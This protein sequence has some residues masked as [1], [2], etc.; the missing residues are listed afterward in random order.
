MNRH[1]R[2]FRVLM[3][4]IAGIA[5]GL[6]AYAQSANGP[7]PTST[8]ATGSGVE[9]SV[10]KI[11]S[12]VRYPDPYK[13]WSK[14]SPV[15][16]VGTGV[17]IKGKRIL[18]N[19]HVVSYASDVQIQANQAGDKLS[20]TVEYIAPGIDLA[21]LKLDDESF[22]DTHPPLDA[23]K[24]LPQIKDPVMAYGYPEGGTSLSITRGIVSRIEFSGYNNGV[25]GLR[26]Q[27]DAAINPGNSGGPAVVG[28]KMVGLVF[29]RLIAAENI[30]YIIPNEEINLFLAD[31]ADGHY[32]GKPAI[33]DEFQTM[34]NPSLRAFLKLDKSVTGMIVHQP[35]NDAADYPLK[36]WDVITHIGET[37]V[38]DQGMIRLGDDVRVRFTYL[39]QKIAKDGKVPLTI[40]RNGQEMKIQ[41]PVM[42][43]LPELVP[44][45][46]NQ[47][48][49]YFIC[50]PMVFTAASKDFLRYLM[51]GDRNG[52]R[53]LVL[54]YTG[55]PLLKR[56]A[57]KPAFD[58]E[59][60]VVV[61]S[62]FFPHRLSMGFSDPYC[63]V[64][65]SINGVP[66]KNLNNLVAIIRDLKDEFIS[67]EFA[68]KDAETLIFPRKEMIAATDEILT[69]NGIRSQGSPDAMMVWNTK[70]SM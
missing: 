35:F 25:S 22:F 31:I 21:V 9:N 17:V 66:V 3:T 37:P 70:P 19:A 10:V 57:D 2:C 56:L 34:E 62:P 44:D 1:L 13:P 28:N 41:L 26:V 36:Q 30:S 18:T 51:V 15:D 48:P 7:S 38:D 64:V 54:S 12:T 61:A 52:F 50:G 68:G 20:A 43:K 24:S 69:D 39:A 59:Q 45:L 67:V 33:F 4:F 14:Q 16:M 29:S 42:N 46:D 23:D 63:K 60:I 8:P 5:M 55:S 49:S 11:F 6:A 53:T 47:Y 27:I 58:G 32:D 40:V 65:K